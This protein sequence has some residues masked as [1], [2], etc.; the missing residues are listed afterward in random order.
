MVFYCRTTS[1]STPPRT[2]Q[3]TCCPFAQCCS[4]DT[5]S[6]QDTPVILHG[7]I[8]S[9]YTGIYTGCVGYPSRGYLRVVSPVI[10]HGVVSG[11]IPRVAPLGV[12]EP[13]LVGGVP[14]DG[15]RHHLKRFLMKGFI[16]RKFTTNTLLLRACSNCYEHAQI[17]T[18]MLKLIRK[19]R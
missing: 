18:S 15:A 2:P 14:A 5:T 1:A 19:F 11:S 16:P 17:V 3:R 13:C 9:F 12:Q 8:C 4:E 7:V 10:L 6:C